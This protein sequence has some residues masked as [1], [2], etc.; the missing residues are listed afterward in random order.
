MGHLVSPGMYQSDKSSSHF[1]DPRL[2]N[3]RGVLDSSSERYTLSHFVY[4]YIY[5]VI[6]LYLVE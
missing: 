3:L 2:Q 4:L 5:I 6:Q 1:Y